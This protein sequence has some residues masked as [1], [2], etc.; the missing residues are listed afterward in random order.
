[1]LGFRLSS[2]ALCALGGLSDAVP[3]A[4]FD[5]AWA[6]TKEWNTVNDPV[7]GGKSNSSF[8][9]DKS[10]HLG[11][12]SGEV[13]IVPFLGA[14]GFCN[15]QS[16]GLG[17]TASFPD[18]SASSGIV[19]RAR[20]ASAAGLKHFNVQIV[21]RGAKHL[22]QQG[23]YMANFSLTGDMEDHF[24]PW[25][26]FTCSWRGKP[27][28]WCPKFETQLDQIDN[29]GLGSAFPGEAGRFTVEMQSLSSKDSSPLMNTESIDLATF[30]GKAPHKWHAENDPVMGGRSSST[31]SMDST[32]ADYKGTTRIVPALKA[33]GFTIALT[34]GF[35]LLSSFPDVSSMDGLTVSARNIGNFSGYKIAFCDSHINFYRCQLSSFKADLVLPASTSGEFQDVFIPFSKFSDKW[36][37]ATGKHTAENPPSASSL[38]SITQLQIWTEAVEGDFHLQFRSVR[39]TK[40]PPQSPVVV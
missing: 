38:K 10:R 28:S 20:E 36:D 21:S 17:K 37:A 2:I 8:A 5:G 26:A 12:W 18:L 32:Y 3:I 35:P 33:P 30:D 7:M 25:S 39:A 34:E 19:V 27:V 6:T 29:M 14:P 16:P 13:K 4:T 1:M 24:I 9:V 40:A 23:V 15:L 31:V 11:V 22:L